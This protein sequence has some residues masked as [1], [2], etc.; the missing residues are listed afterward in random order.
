MYMKTELYSIPFDHFQRYAVA[1]GAIG[2]LDGGASVLEVGANRQRLLGDFLP[3]A[4]LLYTD[5]HAEGDETDFVVADATALPFAD[6]AFD[7]VV[8]LDVLEHIPQ[9]I[10][11]R[12]LAEMSRVS[13]RMVLIG[14]PIDEP[15]VHAAEEQANARWLELFG[16][17]YPWLKEH[18]EF[19]LVAANEVEQCL[20]ES[21]M[22]VIRFGQGDPALWSS[23][24]GAHFLKERFPELADIVGAADR[25]YNSRV[26]HGDSH[27]HCYR[28]YFLGLRRDD[29]LRRLQES[30]FLVGESDPEAF[31]LLSRLVEGLKAITSRT[32]LA[33]REWKSTADMLGNYVA[34]LD[35]AKRE[36]GSTAVQVEEMARRAVG[37]EQDLQRSRDEL[38]AERVEHVGLRQQHSLLQSQQIQ[39]QSEHGGLQEQH[40]SLQRNQAELIVELSNERQML[41]KTDSERNHL[42][43]ELALLQGAH[44]ELEGV[45]SRL[46]KLTKRLAIASV[47]LGLCVLADVLLRIAAR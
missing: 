22:Q 31:Q 26:F 1:A 28:E 45:S 44:R 47:V 37:A 36:W 5:L 10:R 43:A 30:P 3:G 29:D 40:A 41:A 38:H 12:A 20:R 35:V 13:A 16:Y 4:K 27:P 9:E 17:D 46:R 25:L 21:G 18:K 42:S 7:A 14:C 8:S 11:T 23:L 33:E 24:M 6:S 15:W 19:G 32:E 39:L 2:V 34:D